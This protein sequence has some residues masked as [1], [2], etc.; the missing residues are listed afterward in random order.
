MPPARLVVV[1]DVLHGRRWQCGGVF[2]DV[3]LY[4]RENLD[5]E[6]M[7]ASLSTPLAS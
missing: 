2:F 7:V 5:Y 1:I 6:K 4:A 3:V